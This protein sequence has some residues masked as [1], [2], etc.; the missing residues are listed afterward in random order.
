MRHFALYLVINAGVALSGCAS[1]RTSPEAD[2]TALAALRA[3][4]RVV[5]GESTWVTHGKGYELVGRT[6]SDLVA[7]QPALDH[8]SAFLSQIYPHDSVAPIVATVRRAP[9]PGKAFVAAAPVPADI[10]GIQV[11]LVLVDPKALEEQRKK[12][13][14]KSP[15]AE[16]GMP[17]GSPVTPAVR[18]WLSSRASRL[19]GSPARI[20]QAHGEVDDPR[21]P[22]WTI[23]MVGA[24]GYEEMID[25]FTKSLAAHVETVTPLGRYFT[26]ERPAVME[27]AGGRRGGPPSGDSPPG[28]R[29]GMGGRGGGMGG[30]RGGMGGGMGGGRGGGMGGRGAPPSGASE[31][32]F[33]LQG[34]ALFAA[35]SAVLGKYF[36]RTGYEVVGELIDAQM[37]GMPIDDV[38]AK[39]NLG[40]LLQVDAEWRGWLTQRADMLNRR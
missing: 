14:G 17:G 10:R 11:E 5:R 19:T 1:H 30:G 21:V 40:S 7:L 26:M 28:D 37:T 27:M 12:R 15:G 9:V 8:A 29:G 31:R 23:E 13:D 38:F 3:D 39:H 32:T 35:Q 33:P 4:I 25:T 6:R 18:A 36:A 20:N 16:V 34:L 22:A 2:P 24:A